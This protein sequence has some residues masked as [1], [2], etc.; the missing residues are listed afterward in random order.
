MASAI[1]AYRTF[2]AGGVWENIKENMPDLYATQIALNPTGRMGTPQEVASAVAFLASIS[3]CIAA[4]MRGEIQGF[5]H[6]HIVEG[7]AALGHI[8]DLPCRPQR[9]MIER[10]P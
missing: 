9:A 8:A 2:F 3:A 4:Q 1:S 5:P 7:P 6:G 10:P